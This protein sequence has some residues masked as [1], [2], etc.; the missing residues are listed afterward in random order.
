MTKIIEKIVS[1]NNSLASLPLRFG[2]GVIMAAHGSQKLFGAFGGYG[3]QGTAGFFESSLGMKPGILFAALAGG[4]EFFGGLLLIIG[5]ATRPA[6][7]LIGITM[8]VALI[9]VHGGEFFA[10]KGM[11]YPLI[12]V[13]TSITLIIKGGGAWS[14]D[15]RI[16]TSE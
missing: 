10:P 9:T 8:L 5:L 6:A 2:L 14:I 15:Q 3:L 4:S 1:T 13:L 16:S 11:E 12:L 7:V